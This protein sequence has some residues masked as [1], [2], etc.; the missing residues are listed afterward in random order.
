MEY[1]IQKLGQLAG[2]STRTLRY[3]DEIGI[4]KPARINSSGYR[5]Y[6]AAEVN[7]LQQILFFRELG[8]PLDHIKQVIADPSYD[9]IAALK[10]HRRQ[11]LDRK[12]QLDLLIA[13]VDHTISEAE[14]R[15]TMTDQEKFTGFKEQLIAKNERQYG[16]EI[17]EK[18]GADTI[19]KA[20]GKLRNMTAEQYERV[21]ALADEVIAALLEAYKTG[22]PAGEKAQHAAELHKEWLTFYWDTYNKEAHAGIAQMYVDDERFRDYYDKHQTGLAQF[23]LDA[24]HVYINGTL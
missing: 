12:R 4:L 14:G 3:Y 2:I 16:D 6:G 24:I 23:L 9:R 20:N 11:L 17:R 8:L 1:T 5:I 18:Y 13:N 10:Q 7:Q 22:D 15:I 21:T 19:D